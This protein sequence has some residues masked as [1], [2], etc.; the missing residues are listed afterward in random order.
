MISTKQK[1]IL[2]TG[3]SKGIGKYLAKYYLDRGMIVLGCSRT[4]SGFQNPNYKHY[5][6]NICDENQVLEMFS[7]IKNEYERNKIGMEG[8]EYILKYH[9]FSDR[10]EEVLEVL[11]N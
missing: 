2:I 6:L 3:T 10:V 9:K 7:D 1:V 5:C 11:N 4:P 8:R